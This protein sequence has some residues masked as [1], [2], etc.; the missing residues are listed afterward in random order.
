[1][2][3]A[4]GNWLQDDP[5]FNLSEAWPAS[6]FPAAE[7]RYFKDCG[8]LVC[9]LAVMLR[10][11]GIEGEEDEALFNP[12]VLNQ[13]LIECGAFT[14]EADLE[15]SDIGRLYPLE[16]LGAVPYSREALAQIAEYGRPCLV[17]V[18]G[19]K[20]T[21]HFTALLQ[22]LPDDAMVFDP[23]CGENLLG[24]YDR[25]FEIRVFRPTAP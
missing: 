6:L 9:A 8:C 3:Q 11:C 5:L 7:Y 10:H 20:A 19:D 22:M 25:V 2:G 16:Y 13:R 24:T 1:M 17:T 4:Y 14:P 15:L 23:C 18:P 21:M 12:W